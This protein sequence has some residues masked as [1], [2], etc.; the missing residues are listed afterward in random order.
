MVKYSNNILTKFL[1]ILNNFNIYDL[2][3]FC[4]FFIF[5][6]KFDYFY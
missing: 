6:I 3:L 2:Y 4:F 5:L 1:V